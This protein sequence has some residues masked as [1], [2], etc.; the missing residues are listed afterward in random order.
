MLTSFLMRLLAF[1]I[2]VPSIVLTFWLVAEF[3]EGQ[4]Q[5][6]AG[7]AFI[8]LLVSA[9]SLLNA[10]Y[11]FRRGNKVWGWGSI[12]MYALGAVVM[13]FL[14]LG[15]WNSTIMGS[16]T[17]MVR[18]E[19]ARD[20]VELLKEQQREQL[21]TGR[22]PETADE[23][24]AKMDVQLAT[25]IGNQPLGKITEG[26][27]DQRSAAFRLCGEYLK[28]KA[29]RAKAAKAEEVQEI[30]WKNGTSVETSQFKKDIFSGAT[31]VSN[32]VGGTP[33]FWAGFFSV[34]LMLLLMVTRDVSG[35]GVFGPAG[36]RPSADV[37]KI[38]VTAREPVV[39]T[40]ADTGKDGALE[41]VRDDEYEL[42]S[43]S[44]IASGIKP[45]T[46]PS[47]GGTRKRAPEVKSEPVTAVAAAEATDDKV[48]P[49]GAAVASLPP[50][51]FFEESS[52]PIGRKHTAQ[53]RRE[54][55]KRKA[56][57]AAKRWIEECTM[58]SQDMAVTVSHEDAWGHYREWCV[59]EDY[60]EL[61]KRTFLRTVNAKIGS[62]ADKRFLGL[63]LTDLEPQ[64]MR[65]YG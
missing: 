33:T 12:A 55:K 24:Q 60:R 44:V 56:I 65:A 19:A 31:A 16:H 61:P 25:P 58:R 57:G 36:N 7:L 29:A 22:A 39:E 46:P 11:A 15:Y 35:I 52:P 37:I 6:I 18:A 45:S 32:M 38:P 49:F 1:A 42:P 64:Q 13:I 41:L 14:E 51:L 40:Y 9:V 53:R 2:W 54:E 4:S 30:I 50:S 8:S 21:R 26:C 63:V 27:T 3:T 23:I 34:T 17:N 47:G 59:A 10:R 48:I 20:G 43:P 28:L 5:I 62:T